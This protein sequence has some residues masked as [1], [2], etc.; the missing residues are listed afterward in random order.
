MTW[1]DVD[2]DRE[3]DEVALRSKSIIEA[4]AWKVNAWC[5]LPRTPNL[6]IANAAARWLHV[7]H[8]NERFTL[9]VLLTRT[10]VDRVAA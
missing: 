5:P 3:P 4:L 7:L 2:S 6:R 8:L 9:L 1:I 10:N